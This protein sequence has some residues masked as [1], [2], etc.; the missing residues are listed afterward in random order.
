MM[1]FGNG[2]KIYLRRAKPS[3]LIYGGLGHRPFSFERFV[4]TRVCH[5]LVGFVLLVV[6]SHLALHMFLVIFEC[7]GPYQCDSLNPCH[8]YPPTKLIYSAQEPSILCI[9]ALCPNGYGTTGSH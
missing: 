2:P 3:I 6:H 1:S 8:S 5:P 9:L 4:L 7:I